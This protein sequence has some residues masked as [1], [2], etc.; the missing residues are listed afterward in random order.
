MQ[1][2][3]LK[4]SSLFL[5]LTMSKSQAKVSMS[6]TEHDTTF[7]TSYLLTSRIN[8]IPPAETFGFIVFRLLENAF[9]KPSIFLHNA[10]ISPPK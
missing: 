7:E 6:E 8:P 3:F 2:V 5:L 4:F 10:I 9:V 1:V